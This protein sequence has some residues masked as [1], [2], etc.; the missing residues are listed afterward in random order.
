MILGVGLPRGNVFWV[1][2]AFGG[3]GNFAREC[4]VCAQERVGMCC[5]FEDFRCS[6]LPIGNGVGWV[7]LDGMGFWGNV[8]FV[9]QCGLYR[10]E[11]RDVLHIW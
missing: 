1:G 5:R 4:G 9:G 11:G 8:G 2:L 7:G 6:F 3:L 10:E